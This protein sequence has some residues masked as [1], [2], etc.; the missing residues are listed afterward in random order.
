MANEE[1][2][3]VL[4]KYLPA[5]TVEI[6]TEWIVQLNIHLRITKDRSSK[7]GDYRPVQNGAAHIITVNHNLNRYAF[8]ITFVH[9]VAHLV[10]EKK[11]SR[12][13]A[14]HGSHWKRE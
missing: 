1:M 4:A 10:C 3:K 5:G 2:A 7:F 8:L 14:P 13:V 11:Y 6:C 9:E 12:S